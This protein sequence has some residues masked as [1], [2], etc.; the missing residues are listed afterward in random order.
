MGNKILLSQILNISPSEMH[1]WKL[2]FNKYGGNLSAKEH[3]LRNKDNDDFDKMTLWCTQKSM[4]KKG[5]ML[6]G[7]ARLSYSQWLLVKIYEIIGENDSI[8]NSANRYDY[9]IPD[10][11]SQYFGRVII[12]VNSNRALTYPVQSLSMIEQRE[13]FEVTEI[14]NSEMQDNAFP[15]YDNVCLSFRE[16]E[17][18]ITRRQPDWV[19]ALSNQKGVY[20]IADKASG[21]LYVGS[22]TAEQGMLLSRW[23]TY[24]HNGHGGNKDLITLVNEKGFDYIK[25]NFQYSILENYNAKVDDSIILSR[26][27]FWKKILLTRQFGY[28][29]N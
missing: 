7:L 2:R 22:A 29:S 15:N 6:I 26:E 9:V 23:S 11:F 24:V 12:N 18:I 27:S 14:L 17:R 28:N 21:K 10:G 20:L 5:D 3:Y 8:R 25:D 16:L 19:S 1:R 4:F 13:E